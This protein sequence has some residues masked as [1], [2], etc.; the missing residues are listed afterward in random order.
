ME[1]PELSYII[2]V[3]TKCRVTLEDC[4]S[5]SY[6]TIHILLEGGRQKKGKEEEEEKGAQEKDEVVGIKN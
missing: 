3:N 1:Q 5:S 4:L 2:G 6:K